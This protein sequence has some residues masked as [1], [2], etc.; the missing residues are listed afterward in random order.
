MVTSLFTAAAWL[1]CLFRH[2]WPGRI[3]L[4]LILATGIA[5]A[6]DAPQPGPASPGISQPYNHPMKQA[7][8]AAAGQVA[9]LVRKA[10]NGA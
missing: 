7:H 5:A 1:A 3:V 8:L 2:T 10:G 4:A 6:A 9:A